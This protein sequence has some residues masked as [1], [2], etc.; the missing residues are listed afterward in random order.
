MKSGDSAANHFCW[1]SWQ[2]YVRYGEELCFSTALV[3]ASERE[4]ALAALLYQHRPVCNDD[5]PD[6]FPYDTTTVKTTGTN[7][8]LSPLFTLAQ[9]PFRARRLALYAGERR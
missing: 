9:A 8:G 4:R 6:I 1:H 3:P 7:F 5:V 2:R